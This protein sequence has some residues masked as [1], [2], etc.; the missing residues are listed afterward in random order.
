MPEDNKKN[1]NVFVSILSAS[2]VVVI[3]VSFYSF[4][5]KKNYDFYIETNCDPTT[6]TCFYRNCELTP[7][8]CPPN[9]LSYYNQYIIKAR[10]FDRYCENEDCTEVCKSGTVKCTKIECTEDNINNGICVL[11]AND[12]LED[13]NN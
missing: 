12:E 6:E 2:V 11:P 7:D 1:R 9:N 13:A 3:A 10:D 5:Y 8:D 4:Y